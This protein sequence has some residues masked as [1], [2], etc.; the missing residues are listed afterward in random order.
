MNNGVPWLSISKP[1]SLENWGHPLARSAWISHAGPAASHPD[2]LSIFEQSELIPN[3][4]R[5][6]GQ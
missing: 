1:S 2:F 5:P 4:H 6:A 3:C